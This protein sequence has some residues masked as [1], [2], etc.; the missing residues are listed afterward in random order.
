MAYDPSVATPV[1]MKAAVEQDGYGVRELAAE[2]TPTRSA[3]VE[4]TL[5]PITDTML[6]I[7]G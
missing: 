3:T 6:P 7:E 4:A 2:P 5:P 1:L